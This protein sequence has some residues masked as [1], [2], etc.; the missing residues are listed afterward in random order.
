LDDVE[1]AGRQASLAEEFGGQQRGRRVALG[2]LEDEAL[3]QAMESGAIHIGTMN[4]KLK[5]VMPAVTPSGMRWLQFAMP[6]PTL[7]EYC[8][9]RAA[10]CRRRTR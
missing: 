3:P 2:G 4:G 8:P 1:H 10:G 7:S 9:L 6:P 5:G